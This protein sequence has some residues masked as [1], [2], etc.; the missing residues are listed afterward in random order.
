MQNS[1][2]RIWIWVS[3]ITH[4]R[5]FG[6]QSP[7]D[8]QFVRYVINEH[9][10]YYQY[11][12][13]NDTYRLPDDR[14]RLCELYLR[15]SNHLQPRTILD[16]SAD[17]ATSAYLRAGCRKALV[18]PDAPSAELVRLTLTANYRERF[19]A[20]LTKVSSRSVLVIEE[21]WKDPDFWN[22][23]AGNAQT[24]VTFDLYYCGIVMFDKQREKQNYVVNF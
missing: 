24:G 3:R 14:R 1:L 12:T 6:I 19:T 13:L 10:P 9:W 17:E 2:K 15:L 22:E 4:C 21:I 8:Y 11:S 16:D 18:S 7:N 23:V 5:G 20:L